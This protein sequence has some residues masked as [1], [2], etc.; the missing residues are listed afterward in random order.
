MCVFQENFSLLILWLF[1]VFFSELS[2]ELDHIFWSITSSLR[3]HH[4]AY[5][6]YCVDGKDELL[7]DKRIVEV[8]VYAIV[9]FVQQNPPVMEI[10]QAIYQKLKLA[11]M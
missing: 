9:I 5:V 4:L 11:E 6:D 2:L 8:V 7:T 1:R 10:L 3:N